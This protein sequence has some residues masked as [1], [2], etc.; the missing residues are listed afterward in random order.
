MLPYIEPQ[1]TQTLLLAAAVEVGCVLQVAVDHLPGL[2]APHDA[3]AGRDDLDAR[4]LRACRSALAHE[5]PEARDDVGVIAEG[6]RL[7]ALVLPGRE[8]VVEDAVAEHAEAAEGV[9]GEEGA[10]GGLEGHHRL[11]PVHV[12]RLHEVEDQAGAQ[13]EAVARLH[14]LDPL[15]DLVEALDELD[16]LGRGEDLDLGLRRL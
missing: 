14:G 11:G 9:A 5:G 8:L 7:E 4:G 15:L 1:M 10:R 3:V 6:L 12:G 13:V 2:G 16:A